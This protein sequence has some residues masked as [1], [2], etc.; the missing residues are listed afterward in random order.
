MFHRADGNWR[1]EGMFRRD[2]G[3]FSVG[4]KPY[5]ATEYD[6]K[7]YEGNVLRCVISEGNTHVRQWKV[8]RKE[9]LRHET[10]DEKWATLKLTFERKE[11]TISALY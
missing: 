7:Y 2:D 6:A 1:S 11:L 8:H 10:S 9:V 5:D 3:K 4:G